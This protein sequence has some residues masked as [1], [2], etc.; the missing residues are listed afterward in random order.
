MPQ[1]PNIPTGPADLNN[2]PKKPGE[3]DLDAILLPKKEAPKSTERIN[4]GVLLEQEQNATLVKPQPPEQKSGPTQTGDPRTF[5]KGIGAE[6][7]PPKEIPTVQPLQTYRGDIESL[8]KDKNISVVNIA[9]AEAEKRAQASHTPEQGGADE[10]RSLL[11][12]IMMMLGGLVLLAATGGIGIFIY[13]ELTATVPIPED[14]PAPFMTVDKT[15]VVALPQAELSRVTLMQELEKAKQ[16]SGVSL[17]LI[18][19]L[20]PATVSTT[21]EGDTRTAFPAERFLEALASNTPEELVRT[22]EPQYL[23]GVHIFDGPQAFIIL[24]TDSY[25]RAF[26]AMLEWERTLQNDLAPLFTRVPRPRTPEE[27]SATSTAPSAQ[28]FNT[29]F[30]DQI[31]E[32]RDT[33]AIHN[34][35]GDLLLLWTFLD[36]NTIVLTTNEYTLRE[37]IS[38]LGAAVTPGL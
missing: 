17:G 6:M 15:T 8:I 21:L 28:I 2:P 11:T 35:A 5:E 36:R 27:P 26:A 30:V 19:R 23:L 18:E 34:E 7:P 32:N 13:T 9:A 24:R 37:I 33:R 31:V 10:G 4:A 38:R 12:K 3:I 22:L 14:T 25:E 29:G 20:L 1:D 16:A